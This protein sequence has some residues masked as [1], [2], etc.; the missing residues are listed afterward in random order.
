LQIRIWTFSCSSPHACC[1]LTDLAAL[2]FTL[3]IA[4]KQK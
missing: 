1:L 3:V 4:A 2:G